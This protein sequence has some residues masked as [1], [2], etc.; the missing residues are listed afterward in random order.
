MAGL[1]LAFEY[2]PAAY[3]NGKDPVAREKMLVAANLA[4]MAFANSLLGIV[5]SI[6]H[7]FGGEFGVPHGLANAIT[8]PYIIE[9]HKSDEKISERYR[10]LASLL[11]SNS[12]LDSVKT[13]NDRVGIPKGMK[14]FIKNDAAFEKQCDSIVQKAVKDIATLGAPVKPTPE[15]WK[16]LVKL[17]YYGK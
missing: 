14:D 13:L 2:L 16:E 11:G 6:A 12:L 7:S 10:Q 1:K 17:A 5:H 15:Q 3:E 9:F 8:L 4:G